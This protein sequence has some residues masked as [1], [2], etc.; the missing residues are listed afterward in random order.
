MSVTSR[1]SREN[2]NVSEKG[3]KYKV[4]NKEEV[5]GGWGKFRNST[6]TSCTN[7]QMLL[8]ILKWRRMRW[9][10]YVER[11]GLKRKAY[12]IN[13]RMNEVRNISSTESQM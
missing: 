8:G 13:V 2:G 1:E 3:D 7:Q 4:W 5:E 11:M 10:G 6:F 12:N 9:A